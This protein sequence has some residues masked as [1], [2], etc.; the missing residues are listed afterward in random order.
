MIRSGRFIYFILILAGCC[1]ST[2]V[3]AQYIANIDLDTLSEDAPETAINVVGNDINTTGELDI[4]VTILVPPSHGVA[5]VDI[6]TDE[7]KY[8]PNADY[9]GT[10]ELTYQACS[11]EA[12]PECGSA[13]LYITI[14]PV[15]DKPVAVNDN[16]NTYKNLPVNIEP[17]LNDIDADDEGLTLTILDDALHGATTILGGEVIYYEPYLD[18]LGE[19]SVIYKA[20]KSTVP[21][22]CDTAT[23]HINVQST[24]FNA[25][26]AVND[27]VQAYPDND[28]DI[29]VKAN[30]FD[31]DDDNLT[32]TELITT[33]TSG[34][35]VITDVNTVNY[36]SHNLGTDSLY[37]IVCDDNL[38]SRCDTALIYV[39]VV[40]PPIDGLVVHVSNSISPNNDGISDILEIDG[41][42]SYPNFNLKI[43]NRW[44][45]L[46]F[47]TSKADKM[48]DGT[49]NTDFVSS[50]GDLPEGTYFY[51]LRLDGAT[52][53][54]TGFI[55]LKR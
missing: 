1:F 36:N 37:Y 44:S 24:N 21:S 16:V 54:L 17:L 11:I 47:E 51:V 52:D 49:S 45:S 53:P 6:F 3:K 18:F 14:E 28:I 10:D 42:T 7:I 5:Y 41:L 4:S 19:D 33:G 46:V 30:D 26:T 40:P 25:P 13:Q 9:N 8:T 12:V 32:V 27:T 15:D 23:I 22:L 29:D 35:A 55:V 39:N 20:C 2:S 38:P 34:D 48:W 43:Y 50:T 31:G